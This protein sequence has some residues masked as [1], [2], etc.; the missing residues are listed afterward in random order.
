MTRWL[1][2]VGVFAVGCGGATEAGTESVHWLDYEEF[3][4]EI[5]PILAEGCSNPSCHARPERAY[6]LYSPMVRRMD[7]SRTHL[8]EPLSEAELLHN[9]TMSCVLSS[10]SDLPE[11]TLLLRKPLADYAKTHHG[12]GAV[13]EGKSDDRYRKLEGWVARG[14]R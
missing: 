6:S 11:E 7:E 2:A 13:F 10:D 9:F 12:G 1:W 3:R 4:T 8:A 14:R 5:Q